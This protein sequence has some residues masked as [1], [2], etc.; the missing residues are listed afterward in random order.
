MNLKAILPLIFCIA[1][2]V[3][4]FS[5]GLKFAG[6]EQ[7]IDKR[8]SYNVFG[9]S[10]PEFAG[11]LEISFDMALYHE[12]EIGYIFRIKNKEE[13]KVYNLFYDGQGDRI[14]FMLNDEGYSSLIRIRHGPPM[15]R[16]CQTGGDRR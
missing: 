13:Q 10:S 2:S 8:T 7:P 9:T 1:G 6:L 14:V 11:R 4:V 3:P 5:Q 12:S 16:E 15:S